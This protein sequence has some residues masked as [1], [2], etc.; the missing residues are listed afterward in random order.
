MQEEDNRMASK[1]DSY[2]PDEEFTEYPDEGFEE[3]SNQDGDYNDSKNDSWGE[4]DQPIDAM[5]PKKGLD[6]YWMW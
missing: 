4:S 1:S 3:E 6:N 2:Y 5:P